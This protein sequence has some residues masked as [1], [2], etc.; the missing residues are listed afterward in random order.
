MTESVLKCY[1][2]ALILNLI[3]GLPTF[4]LLRSKLIRLAHDIYSILYVAHI[5][6]ENCRIIQVSIFFKSDMA[7]YLVFSGLFE[8]DF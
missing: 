8:A 6:S 1:Q 3:A 4:G 7:L 2:L 5:F